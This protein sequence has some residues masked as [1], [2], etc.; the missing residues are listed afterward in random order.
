MRIPVYLSRNTLQN[1]RGLPYSFPEERLVRQHASDPVIAILEVPKGSRVRSRRDQ[2]GPDQLLVP[3]RGPG[4]LPWPFV[5][6][7][8]IPVKYIV[9]YARRGSFGLSIV[10]QFEA[11]GPAMAGSA[12]VGTTV[13]G[14][15]G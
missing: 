6:R 10:E 7:K 13:P 8:V 9:G 5:G 11:P 15:E 14:R 3:F 1:A 2:H 4:D 12:A